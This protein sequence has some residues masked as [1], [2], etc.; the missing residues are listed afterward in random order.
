MLRL[1]SFFCF[2]ALLL[3]SC[4]S[5]SSSSKSGD[6]SI[7]AIPYKVTGAIAHRTDF[8]TQGLTMYGDQLLESTGSPEELPFAESVLATVNPANGQTTQRVKLPKPAFFGEGVAVLNDR[9]YYVTYK[10]QMGFIYEAGTFKPLGEFKYDNPEGWGLTTDGTH[11]IMSD[12][13][14]KITYFMPPDMAKTKTIDVTIDGQ[15]LMYINELE[16]IDGFIFANVWQT[17]FIVKIDPTSGKVVGQMDL[18]PL[19][20]EANN[21]HP[22][23]EVLNGIAYDT[24]NKKMYVTGK[25]W[26]H[27]FIL[28]VEL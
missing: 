5:D 12:G 2:C 17:N 19:K 23:S 22:Q 6:G 1:L 10:N 9:I 4:K 25:L 26:P 21:T 11:L 3:S 20:R 16:W 13:T 15:P 14:S 7:P 24:V 27:Y 28:D 8:F 18:T